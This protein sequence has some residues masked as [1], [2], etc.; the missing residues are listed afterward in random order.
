ME[1]LFHAFWPHIT[2]ASVLLLSLLAAGHVLIYKRDSRA[3]VGWV[4]LIWL[5]P[6]IGPM[7]YMLLGINRVRR[8]AAG[9]RGDERAHLAQI[10]PFICTLA[11]LADHLPDGRKHLTE[12]VRVTERVTRLDLLKGNTVHPLHN[13]DEAYP[14]MIEAIEHAERSV[15]LTSYIFDNDRTG[16]R[17]VEALSAAVKRGVD[18]RV[19]IDS[20]GARYSIPPVTHRLRMNGVRTAR[21]MPSYLPWSTPYLNLRSHR[22]ILVADGRIGFT[23]G[24][25]IRGN[26]V[27]NDNPSHATRD[28]HFRVTGPV[29][30]ELQATFVEDWQFTTREVLSGETWFAPPEETGA[31]MARAIPDGPDQNYDKMRMAFHGA[32]SVAQRAVRIVTP[33][34]L[35]DA[36]LIGALNTCAMRG[37]QVDIVLPSVNNLKMVAWASMAQMWQILEWDCRVWLSPPPFDHSKLLVVDGAWS[38]I[39]SANWDPRSLRLNFELGLECYNTELAA[40]LDQYAEDLMREARPLTLDEVNGRILPVKLRD[41]LARLF[42]PY[43]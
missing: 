40:A 13:G 24:M 4:G 34:F 12:M 15:T 38:L 2:A 23:G 33:Y 1:E 30:Q 20:V 35:P 37:V 17:F 16:H 10:D 42:A 8:R 11:T 32:L 5:A 27:L 14:A 9:I 29:V 22:K 39:G 26:N 18:V 6:L 28:M 31:V 19:L 21:F 43:L 25:N 36:A 3:A 41:G 7:L